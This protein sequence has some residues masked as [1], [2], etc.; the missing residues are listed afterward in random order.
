M[1]IRRW[2]SA[3]LDPSPPPV[4]RSEAEL[5]GAAA[6]NHRA[7]EP[8]IPEGTDEAASTNAEE[9]GGGGDPSGHGG[10]KQPSNESN[11][12]TTD[13]MTTEDGEEKDYKRGSGC[14]RGIV[15]D[16]KSTVG[17]SSCVPTA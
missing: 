11:G 4:L 8:T 16:F 7:A 12:G 14:G 15:R 5:L 2:N 10:G 17:V 6:Q 3:P 1:A 9:G 13:P